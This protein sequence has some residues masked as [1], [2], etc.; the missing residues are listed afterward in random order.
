MYRL[1]R[2]IL[3]LLS[4]LPLR[5]L[6]AL[7]TVLGW[8]IYGMSPTYRRH[9]RA[10]LAQAGYGDAATRR[11][12]I[13]AAGCMIIETPLLWFRPQAEV[14]ALVREVSGF[15]AV[16]AAHRQGNAL[17]LLT[18]HLGSF[19]ITLQYVSLQLPVTAVYR[20]PKMR[21]LDPLMR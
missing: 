2:L 21:W 3:Q 19:E 13:G 18:P 15:D 9:L 8:L 14:A 12:A 7:G 1:P 5:A 4:L 17:L 10:H 20:P 11:G 6:H 16:L